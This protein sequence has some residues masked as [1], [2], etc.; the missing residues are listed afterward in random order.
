MHPFLFAYS[1]SHIS[2]NKHIASYLFVNKE[3]S[4]S[5]KGR[6]FIPNTVK[7]NAYSLWSFYLRV[8]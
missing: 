6:A 2:F 3:R 5:N 4:A 8:S 7:N 1:F